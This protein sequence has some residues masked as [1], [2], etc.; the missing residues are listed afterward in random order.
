M[1][2]SWSNIEGYNG[3]KISNM[4]RVVGKRGNLLSLTPNVRGY[5]V[6]GLSVSGRRKF[7]YVHRLVARAFIGGGPMVVNHINGIKTDN[8][9]FNLEYCTQKEN[10][11]HAI[12][13]GLVN[14]NCEDNPK[15][16]LDNESAIIIH[17]RISRG[18]KG[19]DIANDYDIDASVISRIK[20]GKAWLIE[21]LRND[22]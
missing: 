15:S 20:N 16:V 11:K 7:F 9:V 17:E 13:T 1:K 4:G 6:V 21:N 5:V 14:I 18:D 10:I 8:R 3:Y 22:D 2:E 12:K 19:V